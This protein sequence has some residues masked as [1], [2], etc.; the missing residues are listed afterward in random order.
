VRG[1]TEAEVTLRTRV[2][3]CGLRSALVGAL[4]AT[5]S[6]CGDRTIGADVAGGAEFLVN[7]SEDLTDLVVVVTSRRVG[8]VADTVLGSSSGILVGTDW[9]WQGHELIWITIVTGRAAFNLHDS[10]SVALDTV[11]LVGLHVGLRVGRCVAKVSSVAFEALSATRW[12]EVSSTALKSG[13]HTLRWAVGTSIANS[14]WR[15]EI[16]ASE[17]RI[18]AARTVGTLGAQLWLHKARLAV[19]TTWAIGAIA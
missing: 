15:R 19:H 12:R 9:A 6:V 16:A 17:S 11:A 7:L 2:A 13:A 4:G 10:V 18:S 14:A 8:T 1:G 5:L 3:R